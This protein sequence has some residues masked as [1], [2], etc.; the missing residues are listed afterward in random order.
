MVQIVSPGFAGSWKHGPLSLWTSAN[1]RSPREKEVTM[2]VRH[3]IIT[4]AALAAS[5]VALSTVVHAEDARVVYHASEL[6][7]DA[8]RQA[9]V[10]RIHRAAN[11]AC[12]FG[13][14]MEEAIENQK[15]VRELSSQMVAKLGAPEFAGQPDG[16]KVA[17]R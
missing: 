6:T 12:G 13:A 16:R 14:T 2:F 4:T 3:L 5:T 7:T 10:K 15:C 1:S 17:S 9:V 11:L 8:G